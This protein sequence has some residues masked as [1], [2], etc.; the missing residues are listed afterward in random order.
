MHLKPS[1]YL[2]MNK[3]KGCSIFDILTFSYKKLLLFNLFMFVS[4]K[5]KININMSMNT[6]KKQ[7]YYQ[8]FERYS[9]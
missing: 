2:I 1:I 6:Y 5:T 4:Y 3:L 7:I 8:I 9:I